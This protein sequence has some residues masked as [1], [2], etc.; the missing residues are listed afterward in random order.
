MATMNKLKKALMKS[1]FSS[2]TTLRDLIENAQNYR[3]TLF[4]N[5][6]TQADGLNAETEADSITARFDASCVGSFV[7]THQ[8]PAKVEKNMVC[9]RVIIYTLIILTAKKAVVYNCETSVK[10]CGDKKR[11]PG[12]VEYQTKINGRNADQ[13]FGEIKALDGAEMNLRVSGNKVTGRVRREE[14]EMP[15]EMVIKRSSIRGKKKQIA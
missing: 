11:F 2:V 4:E 1:F 5:L 13:F 10:R 8:T 14:N 7:R 15:N 3:A 9:E 6:I 12:M